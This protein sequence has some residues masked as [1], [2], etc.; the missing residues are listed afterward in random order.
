VRGFR[1]GF[2]ARHLLRHF[3]FLK[4][5]VVYLQCMNKEDK[6]KLFINELNDIQDDKLREFATKII[7]G[8]DDYFFTVPASSSGKYHPD[9]AREV[10]GLVKHTRAVEFFAKTLAASFMRSQRD[11][12]LL[13]LAAL[14]HDIKKQGDGRGHHTVALHPIYA[15]NYL[16]ACD[17]ANPGLI[18]KEDLTKVCTAVESHMGPWGKESGLP[19]PSSEFDFLL[20]SADYIASRKEIL[21]F[22]FRPTEN[23]EPVKAEPVRT[24]VNEVTEPG[25]YVFTFGKHKGKTIR[26]VEPTGYLDWMVGQADFFNKEAQDMAKKYLAE[27]APKKTVAPPQPVVA[28]AND[29]LPF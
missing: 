15:S 23:A 11:T 26:E 29:D 2:M 3:C 25:D 22:D 21:D 20:Q 27:S 10:G 13:I 9:F 1:R 7:E 6:V 19:V 17:A 24:P 4:T 16:K 18:D 28:L 5:F 14:A 12:D 8:A